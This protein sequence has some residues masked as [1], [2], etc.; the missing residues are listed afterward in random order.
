MYYP[1]SSKHVGISRNLTIKRFGTAVDT[2]SLSEKERSQ[3][4]LALRY[5]VQNT[6]LRNSMK[7]NLAT[8]KTTKAVDPR[9]GE[10]CLQVPPRPR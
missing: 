6:L 5:D 2:L 3:N 1:K 4:K 8:L 7:P 10:R 9:T